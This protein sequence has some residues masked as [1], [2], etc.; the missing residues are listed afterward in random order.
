MSGVVLVVVVILVAWLASVNRDL[1]RL[2]ANLRTALSLI[3]V[4]QD[5][6]CEYV[7]GLVLAV[8]AT[9]GRELV[10]TVTGARSLA[11][12]VRE[13]NL[14][15][16]RQ[17]GAENALSAALAALMG[18][19][20]SYP[21]LRRDWA[22]VRPAHEIDQTETRL[23]GAVTVYNDLARKLNDSLRT[24]PASLLARPAGIAA[25]P[26]FEAATLQMPTSADD[27]SAAE[28]AA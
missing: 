19:A 1:R 25:A 3:H 23:A 2:D 18:T 9:V 28:Q 26:L 11:M 5:R 12:R 22:F 10:S 13:E 17:A 6:R 4:E 14:D 24:F 21:A 27:A 15:L 7:P 8:A 16:G 20:R